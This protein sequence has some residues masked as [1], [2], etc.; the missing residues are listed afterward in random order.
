V[1]FAGSERG[2]AGALYLSATNGG[3]DASVTYGAGWLYVRDK[4]RSQPAF[5]LGGL[6]QLSRGS[7]FITENYATVGST[8]GALVSYGVRLFGESLSTDLAFTNVITSGATWYFP[9]IPYLAFAV[10]F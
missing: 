7:A 8:N 10:K 5:V 4:V 1:G 9:G 2:S 3:V 6:K